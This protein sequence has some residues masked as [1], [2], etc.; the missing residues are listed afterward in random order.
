MKGEDEAT[1]RQPRPGKA[2]LAPLVPSA[3]PVPVKVIFYNKLLGE[4][5]LFL[6]AA[7]GGPEPAVASVAHGSGG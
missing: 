3:P 4:V 1:L 5:T 6:T 2:W 7:S